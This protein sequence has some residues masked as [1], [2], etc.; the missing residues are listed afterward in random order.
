MGDPAGVRLVPDP[1]GPTQQPPIG[2][3]LRLLLCRGAEAIEREDYAT[4]E[5]C[6][7]QLARLKSGKLPPVQLADTAALFA[8]VE[9]VAWICQQLELAPGAPTLV[10]GYG[11]SGKTLV[12]QDLLLRVAAGLPLWGEHQIRRGRA[13]H[14]DYEMGSRLLRERYQ[15]LARAADIHVDDLGGRL[16][17][18]CFP[19]MY[20]DSR[21][22]EQILCEICDGAAVVLVDSLKA[23][24]PSVDE[25]SAD[26]RRML[27]MLTRC[28]ERT[29]AAFIVIHHSRKPSKDAMGGARMAIRGSGALYDAC[30]SVLVLEGQKGEPVIVHHEKA[31]VSGQPATDIALRFTDVAWSGDAR[32]GLLV[33]VDDIELL[34]QSA[35]DAKLDALADRVLAFVRANP[36]CTT[37]EV[38]TR[39][40]GD[41]GAIGAA[42]DHL[43][44]NGALRNLGSERCSQWRALGPGGE[45]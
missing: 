17:W 23:S 37:R 43:V 10:A 8:P 11:Y 29:G 6:M 20:L 39:V 24:C 36:G 41:G 9:P 44:R 38:R 28:S 26:A 3:E 13:I 22:A 18:A 15:R 34:E 21:Q 4:A 1:Q 42:L 7:A 19:R 2:P 32:W 45:A 5:R 14:L 31:R 16:E 30:Q 35:Q 33:E 12:C 27:D 40:R 25:N